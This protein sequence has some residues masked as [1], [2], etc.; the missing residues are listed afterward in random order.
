M[1]EKQLSTRDRT[2]RQIQDL[3]VELWSDII[4]EREDAEFILAKLA[5]RE[6]TR[7]VMVEIDGSCQIAC[8]LRHKTKKT[9]A[10]IWF[11]DNERGVL[12]ALP[13]SPIVM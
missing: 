9:H 1:T 10:V 4:S 8:S 3:A 2:I 5:T 13:V 7:A 6:A 11:S 12:S